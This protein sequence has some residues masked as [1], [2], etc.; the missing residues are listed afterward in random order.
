M[1]SNNQF[2]LTIYIPSYN[3]VEKLKSTLEDLIPQCSHSPDIRIVVQDNHSEIVY[4][5][6]LKELFDSYLEASCVI[7]VNRNPVNI[8][9]G[10]NILKGFESYDSEWLW[11]LSDD[12]NLDPDA[13]SKIRNSLENASDDIGFIRYSSQYS[14]VPDILPINSFKEF[15]DSANSDKSFNNYIFISN[16]IY[17]LSELKKQLIHGYNNCHTYIPHFMMLANYILEGGSSIISPHKIVSYEVP[18]LGYNYAMVAG[19]GVGAPK[20]LLL[21]CDRN[22]FKDFHAIFYPHNDTKVIIDLYFQTR[23]L[24]TKNEFFYLATTYISYL[25][26]SRSILWR[27]SLSGLVFLRYIPKGFE[28]FLALLETFSSLASS[29]IEEMRKRYD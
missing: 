11:I 10:A 9:M 12:D 26:A 13:V 23:N 29:H 7:E 8:G 16:G 27:L 18:S 22:T 3:R 14:S 1:N 25:G 6:A 17:R 20:H 15:V 24:A 5:T 28:L 19:L 21:N 4:K 2:T